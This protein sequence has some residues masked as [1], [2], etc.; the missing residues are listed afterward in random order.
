MPVRD[1][2]RRYIGFTVE[3]VDR[4]DKITI[5]NIFVNSISKHYGVKGLSMADLKLIEY[6]PEDNTGILKCNHIFLR[7][8]RVSIALIDEVQ[9]NLACIHVNQVS[10]T[11]KTLREKTKSKS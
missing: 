3:G 4:L 2:R 8:V 7:E 10:G 11:I 9:G 1:I 6:N 5:F